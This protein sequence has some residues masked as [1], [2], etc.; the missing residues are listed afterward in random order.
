M[1][2]FGSDAWKTAEKK[3]Q[4]QYATE[5]KKKYDGGKGKLQRAAVVRQN[6]EDVQIRT[7]SP[8]SADRW[9]NLKA[10]QNKR[11]RYECKYPQKKDDAIKL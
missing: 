5:R 1:A 11:E 7:A 2:W 8:A 10:K 4:L 9:Q 3:K 6:H